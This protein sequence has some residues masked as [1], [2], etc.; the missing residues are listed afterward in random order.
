[1]IDKSDEL[2]VSE[3]NFAKYN[4][5]KDF[6][7]LEAWKKCREVKLFFY[8]IILPV[9]PMEEKYLLGNQVRKAAIS[10]TSNIAEGYGRYHF[11][12]GM[13]FYRISRASLYELKDHLIS[14]YDLGFITIEIYNKGIIKT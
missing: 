13:Q 4:A 9:L 1:M 8:R 12:E 10:I 11:R 2:P 5:H 7:A 6:P 3:T 14:C